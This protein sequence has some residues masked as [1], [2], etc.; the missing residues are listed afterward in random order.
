MDMIVTFPGGKRVDV[1]FGDLVIKTDQL[2]SDGGDGSAPTP[3][4]TFL[5]SLGA[6]AGIFVLGFCESRQI[7]TA[8]IRIVQK[9]TFDPATH[10]LLDVSLTVEVPPDFPERYHDAVARAADQCAVKRVIA[11]P[12]NISVRTEVK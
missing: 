9:N 4:Q 5:A 7:P 3:F 11:N 10:K 6:C 2:K 8:G 1:G 12:P